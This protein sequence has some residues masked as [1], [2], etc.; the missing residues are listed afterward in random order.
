VPITVHTPGY[1][2]YVD[3]FPVDDLHKQIRLFERSETCKPSS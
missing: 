3:H 2:G 1:P